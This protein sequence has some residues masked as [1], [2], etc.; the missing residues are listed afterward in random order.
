MGRS[1]VRAVLVCL[2]LTLLAD[3]SNGSAA[4]IQ[5]ADT[6]DSS[7]VA[8]RDVSTTVSTLVH[9][10]VVARIPLAATVALA[11]GALLWCRR[12]RQEARERD[13]SVLAWT[14]AAWRGPPLAPAARPCGA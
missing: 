3:P 1:I 4:D 13:H 9:A 7:V 2:M 11:L 8:A 5:K 10:A 6:H 12:P 14:R